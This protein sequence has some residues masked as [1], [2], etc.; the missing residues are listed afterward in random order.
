MENA[1]GIIN[2]SALF[3]KYPSNT[4]GT[5]DR[6]KYAW[7]LSQCSSIEDP[8]NFTLIENIHT[9]IHNSLS[10]ADKVHLAVGMKRHDLLEVH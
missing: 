6:K 9:A 3:L 7:E 8:W 4:I 10:C 2:R 1:E 5:S